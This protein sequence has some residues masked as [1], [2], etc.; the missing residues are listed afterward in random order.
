MKRA[1]FGI[2][3]CVG[4]FTG[5]GEDWP[6]WRGPRGDG[7]WRAPKLADQWP[8]AFYVRPALA[9]LPA[10]A[11]CMQ[12][13]TFAPLLHVAP[14]ADFDQAVEIQN[15]V[16]QGLSSCVMTNDVREAETFLSAVM[17]LQ[18]Q[19]WLTTGSDFR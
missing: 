4:H 14:Y 9:R 11:P 13:E 17:S 6:T 1:L 15:D 18:V 3:F 12:R 16:P 5:W 19:A 10:P 2:A 7:S 8:E